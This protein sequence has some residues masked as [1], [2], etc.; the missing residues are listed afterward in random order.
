MLSEFT[1]HEF[2]PHTH[3]GFVVAVTERGGSEIKSRGDVAQA[4]SRGLFIFNPEEPHAGWMGRSTYWRYR[5]FY[6][7]KAAMD[8]LA[9][10]LDIAELPYFL[11]NR[12]P[13]ED[14]I[15]AFLATHSSFERTLDPMGSRQ[16][17]IE[18]FAQLFARHG[19]GRLPIRSNSSDQHRVRLAIEIM[20]SRYGE[21][22]T[23][24]DLAHPVGVSIYQLIGL[25]KRTVGLTPHSYLTQVRL[26]AACSLLKRGTGIAETA[27]LSGFYDQCALS[28]YFRRC[29]ALSPVQFARAYADRSARSGR[30]FRQDPQ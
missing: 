28:N 10:D 4:D 27:M 1:T 2:P 29:Y 21:R 30:N 22:L 25:F 13:D 26:G 9:H 12:F 23:L 15:E 24:E 20:R 6:L 5:S 16:L 3:D 7:T 14:L 8:Q 17:M 18:A 19:C 11:C